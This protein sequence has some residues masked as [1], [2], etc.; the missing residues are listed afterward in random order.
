MCLECV[1]TGGPL[2]SSQCYVSLT[3]VSSVILEENLRMRFKMSFSLS[4]AIAV[5]FIPKLRINLGETCLGAKEIQLTLLFQVIHK[6]CVFKF[7]S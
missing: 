6:R 7:L 4:S 5:K 1:N 2:L 3:S